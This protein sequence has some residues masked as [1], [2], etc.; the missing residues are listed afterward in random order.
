[1]N[2]IKD[3][4][5]TYNGM[6]TY[7]KSPSVMDIVID[8]G[9]YVTIRKSIKIKGIPRLNHKVIGKVKNWMIKELVGRDVTLFTY[10]HLSTDKYVEADIEIDGEDLLTKV[11]HVADKELEKIENEE[12]MEREEIGEGITEDA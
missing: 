9:F 10:P 3:E 2:A 1:M 7:I 4:R 11:L 6:I 12:Q 8:L 5:R